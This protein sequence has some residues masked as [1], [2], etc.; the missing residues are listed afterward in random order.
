LLEAEDG[1]SHIYKTIQLG[2]EGQALLPDMELDEK[3]GLLYAMSRQAVYK[4]LALFTI[5][6]V[7]LFL[8]CHNPQSCQSSILN[9]KLQVNVR[10]CAPQSSDCHSC[11]RAGDP[12]C[13]WC[14]KPSAC[15]SQEACD[16]DAL[17][18]RA[19]WLNYKSG[20]CPAIRSVE[21]REQ[22]VTVSRPLLVRIENAPPALAGQ[23]EGLPQLYCSF[24][25]PNQLLINVTATGQDV[26]Q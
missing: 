10:L 4:V 19:D 5:S 23:A 7:L 15:T 12:Y 13:G 18:P 16:A 11:L 17:N 14:L 1:H 6:R 20:R 21:P 8:P 25:F 9:C 26:D 2:P 3:N 24:Q 22:Q